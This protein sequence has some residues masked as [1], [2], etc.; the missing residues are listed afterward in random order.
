MKCILIL[1]R[2]DEKDALLKV[3]SFNIRSVQ[4]V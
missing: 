1:S 3:D 4:I 2:L